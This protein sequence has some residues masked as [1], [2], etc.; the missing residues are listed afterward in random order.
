MGAGRQSS[1]PLTGPG[2]AALLCLLQVLK[3]AFQATFRWLQSSPETP[4]CSDLDPHAHL[5]LRGSLALPG[6]AG[7]VVGVGQPGARRVWPGPP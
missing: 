7:A 5:F 1:S 2:P 4:G 3:K 6:D